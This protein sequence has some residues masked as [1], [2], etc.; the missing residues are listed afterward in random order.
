MRTNP[1]VRST[2]AQSSRHKFVAVAPRELFVSSPRPVVRSLRNNRLAN[3][4][5]AHL[6]SSPLITIAS[7]ICRLGTRCRPFATPFVM[8]SLGS[9]SSVFIFISPTMVTSILLRA[10]ALL[11]AFVTHIERQYLASGHRE[12]LDRLQAHGLY[13]VVLVD[14]AKGRGRQGLHLSLIHI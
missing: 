9:S 13:L 2:H 4:T 3:L 12:V 11:V 10:F 7:S 1:E 8:A 6:L 14:V 5:L